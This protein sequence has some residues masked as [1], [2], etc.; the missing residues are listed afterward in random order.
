LYRKTSGFAASEA[1]HKMWRADGLIAQGLGLTPD[2]PQTFFFWVNADFAR[3]EA[4]AYSAGAAEMKKARP[5]P[6]SLRKDRDTRE[7]VSPN[8]IRS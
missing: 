7:G 8:W 1:P 5:K 3:R 6:G 2:W 4:A